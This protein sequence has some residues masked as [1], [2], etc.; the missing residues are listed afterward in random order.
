MYLIY[1]LL[2]CY[3]LFI[4]RD[5]H[6]LIYLY[7]PRAIGKM[8]DIILAGKTAGYTLFISLRSVSFRIFEEFVTNVLSCSVL[9]Q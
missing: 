2:Q 7:C 9:T 4:Y 6:E 8:T 1:H 3:F 5:R